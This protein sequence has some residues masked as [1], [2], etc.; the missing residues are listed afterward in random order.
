MRKIHKAWLIGSQTSIG[1][2]IL[3][4]IDTQAINII[5]TDMDDVNVSNI[6]EALA[7]TYLNQPDAIINC[8][9]LSNIKECEE[10]I[11]K[12]YKINAIVPRNLAICSRKIGA[13]YVHLSTDNV[14]GKE[15]DIPYNE[16]DMPNPVNVYGKSKLQGETFVRE[17]S[18]KYFIIRTGYIYKDKAD[19]FN[20]VNEIDRLIAPT[21][22]EEIAKFIISIM[23]TPEYGVYH[24]G[25]T[26]Y[27]TY[28][29]FIKKASE[30]DNSLH[31]I[32]E[33]CSK[34]YK[35]IPLDQFM[36]KI[37]HLYQFKSWQN[38]LEDY[39]NIK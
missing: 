28:E 5:A 18:Q 38:N 6:D 19:I 20:T 9:D 11:E 24:A 25:S 8:Y 3:K 17:F 34:V 30:L 36:L 33:Q 1:Q 2:M 39:L 29:D 26:G 32:N 4:E 10:D 13:R 16:F 15:S 14:Y 23:N 37:S 22:A 12:A 21:S 35:N 31:N 27:C 7:F